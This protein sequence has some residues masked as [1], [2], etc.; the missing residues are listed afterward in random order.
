MKDTR[1]FL[2]WRNSNIEYSIRDPV[3]N[4]DDD[5]EM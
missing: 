5:D 2:L 4:D 3:I 1:L